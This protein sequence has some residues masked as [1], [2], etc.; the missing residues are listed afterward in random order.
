MNIEFTTPTR[1]G[2]H[3]L[4]GMYG[5]SGSGKTYSAL[6]L[7]KGLSG[8]DMSKVAF[9]DTEN[10]RGSHYCDDPFL[11]G[12]KYAAMPQE[13]RPKNFSDYLTVAINS[14]FKTIIID[15]FTSEWEG[16]KG[17]V[18]WAAEI[19]ERTKKEG[20]HCW[21]KPKAAHK[22]LLN[23]LMVANAH[24]I[25][26]MRGKEKLLQKKGNDG[27]TEI[28]SGG[29]VPMQ[30][31]KLLYEMLISFRIEE[32]NSATIVKSY[33]SII[34]LGLQDKTPIT[35]KTAIPILKW[36]NGSRP[37]NTQLWFE[38]INQEMQ[39]ACSKDELTATW[40][41]NSA[42]LAQVKTND[43]TKY[44]SVLSLFKGRA[45]EFEQAGNDFSRNEQDHEHATP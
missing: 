3:A 22:L 7:A 28:V 43:A 20:L 19:Q 4:I 42:Q 36:L 6:L 44:Q 24:I 29:Y 5:A 16:I 38:T 27:K 39:A 26:C 21:A 18:D 41:S 34:E 12:Y 33:K 45:A 23:Q 31:E 17:V 37:L 11:T 8:G 15:S 14:G 40:K 9:I 13:F 25:L 10:G 30:C 1:Q 35:E 2:Q 32:N